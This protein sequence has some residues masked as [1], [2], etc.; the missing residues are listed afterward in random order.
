MRGRY[1]VWNN[2]Q[3]YI[4]SLVEVINDLVES[5]QMYSTQILNHPESAAEFR[6][7]QSE[8][9]SY[10]EK[11]IRNIDIVLQLDQVAHI[12]EGLPQVPSPRYVPSWDK[13]ENDNIRFILQSAHGDMDIANKEMQ[14]IHMEFIK[15]RDS[16]L[17]HAQILILGYEI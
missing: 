5:F 13:L 8:Q 4:S 15:E 2:A 6:S 10:Y 12:H 9:A 3:I 1:S 11:I 17:N 16:K 7:R 14:I